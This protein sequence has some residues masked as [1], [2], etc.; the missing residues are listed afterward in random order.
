MVRFLKLYELT[1]HEIRDMLRKKEISA[2]EVLDN[3]F[4]RINN[5]EEKVNSYITLTKDKAYKEAE[6]VDKAIRDGE[7]LPDLAGIPMTIKDNMCTE[8][9]ETTCASKILKN[10]V[11]PYDSEVYRRLNAEGSIMV[12]KANMDE[13]A[14]GSSTENS[15]VKVSRNPWDID[16]V[17]GGSSGGSAA[18]VAA[19]EAYFSLGSDTGGSIRQPAALC[20]VVGMKPTYGLVSRYG[21]VAFASSLDQIGPFTKDVE[22]CALVMNCISGH[23][24]KDSTSLNAP[25]FD[26]KKALVNDVKGLK[27]GLPKEYFSEGIDGEVKSIVLE[28]V[29][30]LEDMGAHVEEMSLPYSKYALP[31]Y[32]IAA[33]AE[34]SS[35]LSRY[36]GVRYGYRSD[37]YEDLADLYVKTRSEGFGPEVKRR[38]MLGTYALSS[39]YYDAYYKKALQ[40][41]TLI[42]EDFERAF[43][44]YDV[45]IS[46]T[47]P[48]TAF[49]IGEKAGDPLAMYLSDICTVPVNIAGTAAISVPCGSKEGLPVG[50]QIIGKPLDEKTV[51]QTA[52]AYEK[53][54]R[55]HNM[56]PGL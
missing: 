21:L 53:N 42:K 38:I 39:G 29:K 52:Y 47:T 28:A 13:F 55:F 35:N 2:K 51:L 46:P 33:S 31:V 14:M 41:K 36:D 56:R 43:Q 8:G 22:D 30:V 50:M 37:S 15:A 54:S 10:F 40:V 11:P 12:G 5:V 3:T 16:R 20:G 25:E 9:I 49:G 6:R 18:A 48:T 45:L 26:F 7:K 34:A 4:E 44:S 1:A 24:S 27:I 19:G 23:D 32:Y 17:P